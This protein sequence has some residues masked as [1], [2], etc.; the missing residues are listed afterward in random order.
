MNKKLHFKIPSVS[1]EK[2]S[3]KTVLWITS[4][5]LA[6]ILLFLSKS[7]CVINIWRQNGFKLELQ[8]GTFCLK[9][10]CNFPSILFQVCNLYKPFYSKL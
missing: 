5:I 8:T 3:G 2:F 10:L 6:S 1:G 4:A 7:S 9:L